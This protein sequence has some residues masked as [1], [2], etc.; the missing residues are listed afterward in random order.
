MHIICIMR[1]ELLCTW[2]WSELFRLFG[3]LWGIAK[4]HLQFWRKWLLAGGNAWLFRTC[5]W[6]SLRLFNHKDIQW[7]LFSRGFIWLTHAGP[8]GFSGNLF[9]KK[10]EKQK[11]ILK[12]PFLCHNLAINREKKETWWYTTNF[13]SSLS[14]LLQNQISKN[15]WKSNSVK[16][17]SLVVRSELTTSLSLLCH[18]PNINNK[19]KS[20]YGHYEV[21]Y[22]TRIWKKCI[23]PCAQ[24]SGFSV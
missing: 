15:S 6:Q 14:F 11:A 13:F 2:K 16:F 7:H 3:E 8:G 9:I 5:R 19:V 21:S 4:C 12:A 24:L 17:D 23:F 10:S 20:G 22:P 18:S 1:P